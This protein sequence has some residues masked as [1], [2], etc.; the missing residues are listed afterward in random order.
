MPG[1]SGCPPQVASVH[2][3]A[4]EPREFVSAL[5][6][7]G[8]SSSLAPIASAAGARLLAQ[9]PPGVLGGAAVRPEWLDRRHEPVLAAH[10]N[11][12]L[13]LGGLGMRYNGLGFAERAD[14]AT[15][16]R[17]WVD[18]CLQ[19]FG[20]TRCMFESDVPVDKV[21]YS[22]QLFRNACKRLVRG[23]SASEKAALFAG[24]A[25]RVYRMDD[26]TLA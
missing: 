24:T 5:G 3:R 16:C 25:H 6:R 17:R 2:R 14:V 21:S 7:V 26:V 20:A 8:A 10:P 4:H 1:G 18:T 12:F 13:K 19:A 23:A 15:V 11:V 22:Y 9:G